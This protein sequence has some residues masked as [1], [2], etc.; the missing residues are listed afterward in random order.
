MTIEEIREKYK[1]QW[2]LVEVLEEDELQR[3]VKVKLITHSKTRDEIYEALREY[4]GYTSHFYTG[5]IPREGYVVA[6]YG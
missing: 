1:N 3:P 4:K 5:R 6:F 2:V